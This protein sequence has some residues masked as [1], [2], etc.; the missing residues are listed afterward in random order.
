MAERL[1]SG[2]QIRLQRFNSAS[3]L[4]SKNPNFIGVFRFFRASRHVRRDCVLVAFIA[5]NCGKQYHINT[6]WI[7][8]AFFSCGTKNIFPRKFHVR[9]DVRQPRNRAACAVHVRGLF[10]ACGVRACPSGTLSVPT[11]GAS[12]A[13]CR[14]SRSVPDNRRN[15]SPR[16]SHAVPDV[17]RNIERRNRAACHL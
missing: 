3:H 11:C 16:P 4:Q 13:A 7:L 12:C 5:F 8:S 17:R 15:R 14:A 1:G 6:T 2:L 9:P 10:A